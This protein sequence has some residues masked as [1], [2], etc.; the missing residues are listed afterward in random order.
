M[1]IYD[2]PEKITNREDFRVKQFDALYVELENLIRVPTYKTGN[3][4][5]IS[6]DYMFMQAKLQLIETYLKA[7]E[8]AAF[9]KTFNEYN[10]KHV[11]AWGSSDNL[12]DQPYYEYTRM[13]FW[14]R[15]LKAELRED[16]QESEK[17]APKLPGDWQKIIVA[18]INQCVDTDGKPEEQALNRRSVHRVLDWDKLYHLFQEF[19]NQLG[20]KVQADLRLPNDDPKF[21]DNPQA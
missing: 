16:F 21:W 18:I 15:M 1:G 5:T 10:V 12:R 9:G 13:K 3:G 2:H 19:W 17:P 14:L 11:L 7:F 20:L 8:M 4:S 6:I